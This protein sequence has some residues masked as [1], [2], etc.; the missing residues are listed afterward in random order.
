MVVISTSNPTFIK[1]QPKLQ[2]M[3]SM[4]MTNFEFFPFSILLLYSNECRS[5]GTLPRRPHQVQNFCKHVGKF[6]KKKQD[7]LPLSNFVGCKCPGLR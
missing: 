6:S 3:Y 1:L 7:S 2:G 4:N 5:L